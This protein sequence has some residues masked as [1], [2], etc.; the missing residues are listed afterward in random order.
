MTSRRSKLVAS[1]VV[2]GVVLSTAVIV[3]GVIY[4][5]NADAE[6]ARVAHGQAV[7]EKRWEGQAASSLRTAIRSTLQSLDQPI[8][9]AQATYDST[10]GRASDEARESLKNA[11]EAARNAPQNTL[12][13]I[14]LLTDAKDLDVA[15]DGA[16]TLASTLKA[17]LVIALAAPQEQAA[18]FDSAAEAKQ[19]A[20]KTADAVAAKKAVP[21]GTS[22]ENPAT[23]EA[24]T[25]ASAICLGG[26]TGYAAA[27]ACIN[28][29]DFGI[30]VTVEWGLRVG[31]GTT[32]F[33]PSAKTATI[34]LSDGMGSEFGSSAV[35][36]SV[37]MHEA[38]HASS[39]R[40][41]PVFEDPVFDQPIFP[42]FPSGGH[43]NNKQERYATA[44]AIA[45][46]APDHQAAGEWAYGITSTAEEIA[47]ALRC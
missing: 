10:V 12:T 7:S 19:K 32:T 18:A 6:Q 9:Q 8:M 23:S 34:K 15:R 35:S 3:V 41:E 13:K 21:V 4:R 5:G 2:C 14:D 36:T 40:C 25:T 37:V 22:S 46:G 38:G 30:T 29:L 26:G 24:G 1:L 20:K 28:A 42:Q 16:I 44:F 43:L 45:H 47:T 17:N 31:G 33:N 39:A 27:I 11:I